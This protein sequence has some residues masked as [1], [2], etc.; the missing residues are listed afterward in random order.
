MKTNPLVGKGQM[1]F[2]IQGSSCKLHWFERGSSRL[3]AISLLIISIVAPPVATCLAQTPSAASAEVDRRVASILADWE[4]LPSVLDDI[5]VYT[6]QI[7]ELVDIGKPAVPTLSAALDRTWRDTPMRLLGFTLRAIGDPRSVPALI[8]AFPKT[9]FPV[10]GTKPV[11]VENWVTTASAVRI[12]F[13]L[14]PWI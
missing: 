11:V 2:G 14:G 6:P 3:T 8:R 10:G 5:G 1:L 13:D 4:K 9:L 12:G 7:K